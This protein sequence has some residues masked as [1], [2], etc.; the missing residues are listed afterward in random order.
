MFRCC[1]FVM[2]NRTNSYSS[3]IKLSM[4]ENRVKSMSFQGQ[5]KI[6]IR[7][8]N[9]ENNVNLTMSALDNCFL[10]GEYDFFFQNYMFVREKYEENVFWTVWFPTCPV[11]RSCMSHLLT[12]WQGTG[13]ASLVHKEKTLQEREVVKC[14]SCAQCE[15]WPLHHL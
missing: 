4:H 15:L 9:P 14:G 7:F 8:F 11:T 2:N 3:V 12:N 13:P 1:T 6:F 10:F 5:H